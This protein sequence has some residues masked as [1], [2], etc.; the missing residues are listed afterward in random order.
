MSGERFGGIR[1]GAESRGRESTACA[2][3]R[4]ECHF[5]ASELVTFSQ[6]C[7]GA[8]LR[9]LFNVRAVPNPCVTL[10]KTA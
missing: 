1:C 9:P 5:I 2:Y 8:K 10:M 4:Q 7:I 6:V 3:S